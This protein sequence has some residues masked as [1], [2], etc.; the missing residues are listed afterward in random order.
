MS[1]VYDFFGTHVCSY[2]CL[3]CSNQFSL[4]AVFC[5]SVLIFVLANYSM[6][7]ANVCGELVRLMRLSEIF[8]LDMMHCGVLKRD[9]K[10]AIQ[11]V[12]EF[13][14]RLYC[15]TRML[16]TQRRI[17]CLHLHFTHSRTFSLSVTHLY[18]CCFER[19]F[20]QKFINS[21]FCVCLSEQEVKVIWQKAPHGG[22][23]LRLGVTPGGRKLYHWIPGVGFPISVP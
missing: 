20:A 3:P 1:L 2:I 12:C 7:L 17:Q 16:S 21:D 11:M 14:L 6:K 19:V 10:W 5:S 4:S 22:P 9:K 13:V 15:L 23:I 8:L 18:V